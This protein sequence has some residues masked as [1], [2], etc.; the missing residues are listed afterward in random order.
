MLGETIRVVLVIS[1]EYLAA[2][3]KRAVTN[4]EK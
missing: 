2:N 1:A 3:A 4:R